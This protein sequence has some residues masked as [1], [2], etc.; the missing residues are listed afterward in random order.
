MRNAD[1]VICELIR[2]FH[3]LSLEEAQVI[4]DAIAMRELPDIWAV[5]GKK[6]VLKKGLSFKLQTLLTAWRMPPEIPFG[7]P[8]AASLLPATAMP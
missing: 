6:R 7:Q 3:G 4:V 8:V 5:A 1:W 2:V